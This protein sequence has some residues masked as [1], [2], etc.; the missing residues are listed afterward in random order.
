MLQEVKVGANP[1]FLVHRDLREGR[2]GWKG[3]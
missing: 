2:Y 1:P 3:E